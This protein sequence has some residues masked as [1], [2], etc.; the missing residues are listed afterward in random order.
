V[1]VKNSGVFGQR[2]LT[3]VLRQGFPARSYRT[4][5]DDLIRSCQVAGI[6]EVL[7][8]PLEV[9]LFDSTTGFWPL[10]RAGEIQDALRYARDRLAEYGIGMGLNIWHTIGHSDGGR[11]LNADFPFRSLVSDTGSVARAQICPLDLQW[12]EFYLQ[13]VQVFAEVQPTKIFLDDDFRWQNH[14]QGNGHGS[15][16]CFCS[17]HLRV[18]NEHQGSSY[19]RETLLSAILGNAL[20][21]RKAWFSLLNSQLVELARKIESRVHAISPETEVGLMIS[22]ADDMKREGREWAPLL[23]TLAG[24]GRRIVTRPCYPTYNELPPRQITW[25]H[26]VYQQIFAYLPEG[27]VDFAEID[28]CIPGIYNQSPAHLAVRMMLAAVTGRRSFHLSLC[29]W[30]GNRDTFTCGAPYFEMLAALESGLSEVLDG[31]DGVPTLFGIGFPANPQASLE[32]KLRAN[33]SVADLGIDGLSWAGPLQLAGLPITFGPSAIVALTRDHLWGMGT[34]QITQ[35][36]S[37]SAILDFSAIEFLVEQG[38]GSLIGVTCFSTPPRETQ[39]VIAERIVEAD[40]PSCGEFFQHKPLG[41]H[42]EGRLVLSDSAELLTTL[43][44]REGSEYGPGA[45]TFQN[46]LGGNILGLPLFPDVLGMNPF[47]NHQRVESVRRWVGQS[48]QKSGQPFFLVEGH[49]NVLPIHARYGDRDLLL[50][51][52]LCSQSM[53]GV[54]LR[55]YHITPPTRAYVW[56]ESEVRR[57]DFSRDQDSSMVTIQTAARIRPLSACIFIS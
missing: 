22:P 51:L 25:A 35:L 12:Q 4:L 38:F 50:C 26:A 43:C 55:G 1:S 34:E 20:P 9:E 52:N 15:L 16:N 29:N 57:I 33:A 5:T 40:S 31:L 47:L 23:Q 2:R 54:T 18:F 24:P 45:Y 37:R 49:P 21:I 10:S 27:V 6:S 3:Y 19:D 17:E 14:M 11:V 42:R 36:L 30:L 41:G 7:F 48:A 8:W 13:W 53:Q 46:E 32:K 56:E 44:G 28:N 39:P